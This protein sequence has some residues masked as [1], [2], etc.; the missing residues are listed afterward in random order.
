MSSGSGAFGVEGYGGMERLIGD[1]VYISAA[2]DEDAAHECFAKLS[3]HSVLAVS[4]SLKLQWA[5]P[6]TKSK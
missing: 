2:S 6:L 4:G 1:S 3:L 5:T